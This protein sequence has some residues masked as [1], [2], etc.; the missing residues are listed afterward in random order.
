M[1]QVIAFI[2][3]TT[4][5]V[6]LVAKYWPDMEPLP[7]TERVRYQEPLLSQVIEDAAN[8]HHVQKEILMGLIFHESKY[9]ETAFNPEKES[10][11]YKQAKTPKERRRCGSHSLMQIVSK[12]YG[13]DRDTWVENIQRG[14]KILGDCIRR[15]T[16]IRRGL[17]CYNGDRTGAYAAAVIQDA[18]AFGYKG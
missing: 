18:K 12:W 4:L 3:S 2:L 9:D 14:S 8:K 13:G 1:K 7:R 17:G 10:R 5:P 6:F 15:E 16:T 11:C